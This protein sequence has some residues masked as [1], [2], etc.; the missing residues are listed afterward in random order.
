M[1][2][3]ASGASIEREIWEMEAEAFG[4][5]VAAI[6]A[7]LVIGN[8]GLTNGESIKGFLCEEIALLGAEE[9]TSFGAGGPYLASIQDL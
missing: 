4:T 7:P 5:F 9:V 8:V 6:P 3:S 2:R 1:I